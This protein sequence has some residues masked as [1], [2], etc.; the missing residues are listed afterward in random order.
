MTCLS[1]DANAVSLE[2]GVGGHDGHDFDAGLGNDHA[3]ER[4][5]MMQRQLMGLQ[6]VCHVKRQRQDA[7][8]FHLLRDEYVRGGHE[9]E[10]FD[11]VFDADFPDA[12]GA[13]EELIVRI[14]EKSPHG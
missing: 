10:F 7:L 1:E 13:Q 6:S 9:R 3:V 4:V 14:D 12:C 5:A 11:G 2:Y 8:D